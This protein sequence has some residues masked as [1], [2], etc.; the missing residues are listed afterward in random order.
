MTNENA[1][2][3]QSSWWAALWRGL[4]VDSQAKHY[5]KMRSALWLFLYLVLHADRRGGRLYRKQETIARDMGVSPRTIRN[6]LSILRRHGYVAVQNSGRS[7]SIDIHKW[8]P[9]VSEIGKPLPSRKAK[10]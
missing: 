1:T 5:R 8:K 10:S 2:H 4:V 7:L 9:I 3:N 6:W